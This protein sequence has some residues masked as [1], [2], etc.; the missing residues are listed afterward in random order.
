MAAGERFVPQKKRLLAAYEEAFHGP[1]NT[2]TA[3]YVEG[4]VRIISPR[5]DRD[6][7]ELLFPHSSEL[8]QLGASSSGSSAL[9]KARHRVKLRCLTPAARH[10]GLC[11]PFC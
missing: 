7:A 8:N 10:L 5:T 1:D 11:F 6:E 3:R 4:F 2:G 9:M